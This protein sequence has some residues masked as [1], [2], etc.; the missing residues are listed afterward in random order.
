M[1]ALLSEDICYDEFFVQCPAKHDYCQ[2]LFLINLVENTFCEN[3]D[4]LPRKK[5]EEANFQVKYLPLQSE[6]GVMNELG[7]LIEKV[8]ILMTTMF[9]AQV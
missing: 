8:V 2:Y 4:E 7:Q 6:S 1:I 3:Q 9:V 5:L